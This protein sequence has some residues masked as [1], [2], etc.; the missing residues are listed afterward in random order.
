MTEIRLDHLEVFAL[1]ARCGGFR[2]AAARRGVSSSVISQKMSSWNRRW[3]FDCS[4][5]RRA[6]WR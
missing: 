1:I 3:D 5:G 4:T 6:A 2:A